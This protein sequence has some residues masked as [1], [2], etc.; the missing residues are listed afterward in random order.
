MSTT[1]VQHFRDERRQRLRDQE[2]RQARTLLDKAQVRARHIIEDATAE[3]EAQAKLI[4]LKA[5]QQASLV[6][7]K[8]YNLGLAKADARTVKNERI[9]KTIQRKTNAKQH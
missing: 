7:E 5:E 6:T 8:A 4:I 3:A 1:S 2:A 9:S